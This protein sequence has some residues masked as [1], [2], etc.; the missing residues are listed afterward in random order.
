[1][2]VL[3]TVAIVGSILVALLVL[4]D[5]GKTQEDDLARSIAQMVEKS[6]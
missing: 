6:R 1:M 5:R 2:R 4:F 3:L